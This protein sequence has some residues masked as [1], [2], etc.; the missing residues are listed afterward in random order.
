LN[1]LILEVELMAHKN[2]RNVRPGMNAAKTQGEGVYEEGHVNDP[3]S[4]KQ[5]QFNK[6]T[7]K[8]Q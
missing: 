4:E 7:K 3:L 5:K 6:K 1:K 8:R 2:P